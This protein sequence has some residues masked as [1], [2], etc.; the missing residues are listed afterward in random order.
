MGMIEVVRKLRVAMRSVPKLRIQMSKTQ[1]IRYRIRQLMALS[2]L[3]R[4]TYGLTVFITNERKIIIS[5][6][7]MNYGKSRMP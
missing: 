6:D 3:T 5:N 2:H 7:S 4:T 1:F